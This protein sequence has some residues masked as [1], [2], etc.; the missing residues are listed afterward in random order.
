MIANSSKYA[1]ASNRVE[2]TFCFTMNLLS[3]GL[4][5][6]ISKSMCASQIITFMSEIVYIVE[7]WMDA[8]HSS[9]RGIPIYRKYSCF[10]TSRTGS[11]FMRDSFNIPNFAVNILLQFIISHNRLVPFSEFFTSGIELITAHPIRQTYTA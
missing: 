9:F 2:V 5:T 10:A 7:R 1:P 8:K 4:R 6:C 3:F 11:F